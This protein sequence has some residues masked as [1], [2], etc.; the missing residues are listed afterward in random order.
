MLSLRPPVEQ[1]P[2][3]LGLLLSVRAWVLAAAVSLWAS[4]LVKN[5]SA[6]KVG[7]SLLRDR[8]HG[9][10]TSL[11]NIIAD[12]LGTRAASTSLCRARAL[13]RFSDWA[14]SK[15][16]VV[17]S[18]DETLAYQYVQHLEQ[19]AAAPTSAQ[20][21]LSA[22]AFAHGVFR[23][24]GAQSVS[25]S[26]RIKGISQRMLMG[27]RAIDQ[28]A[29][30]LVDQVAALENEVKYASSV[31]QR[32]FAGHCLSVLP[33]RARWSD[34]QNVAKVVLDEDS[35]GGG[36]L[37]APTSMTKTSRRARMQ[38]WRLPMAGPLRLVADMSWA[39]AW[40]QARLESGLPDEREHDMPMM[41]APL[42]TGGWM[43]R[44]LS[45][46]EAAVW[47]AR[48]VGSKGSGGGRIKS[49]S[50]KTTLLSW[51]AKGSISIEHRKLLGYHVLH[52]QKSALTYS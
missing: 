10:D 26:P 13:K 14:V 22:L 51:A 43:R 47:L 6:S 16:I 40:L 2:I 35:A 3:L 11:E 5:L 30:L 4:I 28:A 36:F 19:S 31:E 8:E 37:E 23:W 42:P 17:E 39:K 52:G 24:H 18:P 48:I 12:A 33:L 21:F 1:W 34:S 27:R 45:T 38:G 50:L 15:G 44:P 29:P 7:E 25:E 9:V 20:S 49:H 41:P 46:G 32:V